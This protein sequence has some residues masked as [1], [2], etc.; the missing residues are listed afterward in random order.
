MSLKNSQTDEGENWE[1][2]GRSKSTD[3]LAHIGVVQANGDRL[4][5]ARAMYMYSERPWVEL[6]VVRSDSV[7]TVLG[8]GS[9]KNIGFA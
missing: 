6:C 2:F 5:K 4:A 7:H 3:S 1:V 9:S 8:R